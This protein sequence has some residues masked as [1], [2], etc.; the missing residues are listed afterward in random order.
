MG[1]VIRI[2]PTKIHY[3]AVNSDKEADLDW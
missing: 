3:W 2:S 1:K